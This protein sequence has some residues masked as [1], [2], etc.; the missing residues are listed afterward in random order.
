[1]GAANDTFAE[2][3]QATKLPDKVTR[4]INIKLVGQLADKYR[5]WLGAA[6]G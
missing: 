3:T 5:I 4:P 6:I 2:F 1:M